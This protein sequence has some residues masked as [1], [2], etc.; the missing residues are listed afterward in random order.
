M[1]DELNL[2]GPGSIQ[3]TGRA[4]QS[5]SL[6]KSQGTDFKDLLMSSIGEVNRLQQEAQNATEKLVT[7]QTSNVSEVFSAVRKAD[8]AFSLLMQIRNQLIDAYSEI[9]NMRM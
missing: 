7:G 9:R 5:G 8:V 6:D 2:L 1:V 3:P 4:I